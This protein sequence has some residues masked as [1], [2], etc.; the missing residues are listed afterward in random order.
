MSDPLRP[1]GQTPRRA[2]PIQPDRPGRGTGHLDRDEDATSGRESPPS[3]SDQEN[4]DARIKQSET[5]LDN[6]RNP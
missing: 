5:A 6:V 1:P 2:E 4:L 3:R